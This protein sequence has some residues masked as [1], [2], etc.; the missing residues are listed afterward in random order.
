[1]E[2][3]HAPLREIEGALDFGRVVWVP[4][5]GWLSWSDAAKVWGPA[6]DSVPARLVSEYA[7]D[8]LLTYARTQVAA[9]RHFEAALGTDLGS[10]DGCPHL[11]NVRNGVVDLRTGRLL[12]H[13]PVRLMTRIAGID[14]VPGATSAAWDRV[15]SA[16]PDAERATLQ[17]RV[18]QA[19]SGMAPGR[20]TVIHGPADAGKTTFIRTIGRALGTYATELTNGLLPANLRAARLAVSDDVSASD[21]AMAK[22]WAGVKL[23]ACSDRIV[24]RKPGRGAYEFE[25]S[26][27]LFLVTDCWPPERVPEGSGLHHFLPVRFQG[28][29]AADPTLA[30]RACEPDALRAALAWAVEGAM[31]VYAAWREEAPTMCDHCYGKGGRHHVQCPHF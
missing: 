1:M 8:K 20:P 7:A 23:W 4:G 24:V 16:I 18:G 2:P 13:D 27:D 3:G 14:Y 9:M 10:L 26:H 17:A 5:L 31:R 30:Q 28:P 29:D 11:L 22:W 15:L 6:D 25:P 19:V 12:P 21:W